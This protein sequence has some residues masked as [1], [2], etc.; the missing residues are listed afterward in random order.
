V[1]IVG[2]APLRVSG[3]QSSAAVAAALDVTD[4]DALMARACGCSSSAMAV[5]PTSVDRRERHPR[6]RSFAGSMACRWELAAARIR[7]SPRPPCHSAWATGCRRGATSERQP[8]RRTRLEP[9]AR[10]QRISGCRALGVFAGGG[11][12][13]TAESCEIWRY[14]A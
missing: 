11:P 6:R 4:P 14:R 2:R 8:V 3:E 7:S 1:V 9:T 12:I 10:I 5:R 13:E